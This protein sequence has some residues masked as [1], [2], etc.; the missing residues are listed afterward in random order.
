[1]FLTLPDEYKEPL[2]R[3]ARLCGYTW[4][5]R[6]NVKELVR[7]IAQG[8][9][10]PMPCQ[11]EAGMEHQAKCDRLIKE[12]Q[13][14]KILYRDSQNV[15]KEWHL[16][17]AEI[18]FHEKRLYL[19]A[20]CQETQEGDLPELQ[21]NSCFRFDRIIEISPI[22]VPW[23][24]QGLD[25][26]TVQLAFYGRLINAYE[27]RPEDV[28]VEMDLEVLY[29]DREIT[30]GFYFIRSILSYG[31]DCEVIAPKPLRKQV[32]WHFLSAAGWYAELDTTEMRM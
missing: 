20:W 12:Q 7:A 10:F 17:Y 23:R 21:H 4:G 31:N 13:P 18:A 30:N 27:K 29:C 5:E 8:E 14:F 3:I 24:W 28:R 2:E 9:R 19:D 26:L 16:H 15:L 11:S 6:G 32:A 22:K 1:M 25:K